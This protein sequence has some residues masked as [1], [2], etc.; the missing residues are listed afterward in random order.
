MLSWVSS[1][2]Q[3]KQKLEVCLL[4]QTHKKILNQ[5]EKGEL[6]YKDSK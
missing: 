2:R 3:M 6:Q 1:K 4:I 5:K